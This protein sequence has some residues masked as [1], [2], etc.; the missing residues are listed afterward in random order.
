MS[1]PTRA[2]Q[3]VLD[4]T[5]QKVGITTDEPRARSPRI[6]VQFIGAPYPV[7]CPLEDLTVVQIGLMP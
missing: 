3:P 2:G 7:L 1:R 5:T 6:P 4:A